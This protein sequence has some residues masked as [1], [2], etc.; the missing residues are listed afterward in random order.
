MSKGISKNHLEG[1]IV[2]VNEDQVMEKLERAAWGRLAFQLRC[3]FC[4]NA[5]AV[6]GL[7]F[8][9]KE[10]QPAPFVMRV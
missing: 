3:P 6:S 9:E 8:Y 10:T 1:R 5:F 2:V 7:D 4:G